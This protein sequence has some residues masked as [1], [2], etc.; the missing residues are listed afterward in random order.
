M[1]G[2]ISYSKLRRYRRGS[3]VLSRVWALEPKSK[4]HYHHHLFPLTS[5]SL[6]IVSS[7]IKAGVHSFIRWY[8]F[9]AQC[10]SENGL[11]SGHE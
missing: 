1:A 4:P 2:P 8:L 7:F 10:V 6:T 9:G 5:Y 3:K 11:G